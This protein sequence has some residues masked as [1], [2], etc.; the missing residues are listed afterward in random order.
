MAI[1]GCKG[2]FLLGSS[3]FLLTLCFILKW[4]RPRELYMIWRRGWGGGN[5]EI[6]DPLKVYDNAGNLQVAGVEVCFV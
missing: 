6:P 2:F 3:F 1:L 5:C 4:W